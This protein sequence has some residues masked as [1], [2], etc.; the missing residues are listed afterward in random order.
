MQPP[1]ET[2]LPIHTEPSQYYIRPPQETAVD[3]NTVPSWEY[4][5]LAQET[6]ADTSSAFM[7]VFTTSTGNHC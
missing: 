6:T 3:R 2:N 4:V 7:G 5:Q 1:Q